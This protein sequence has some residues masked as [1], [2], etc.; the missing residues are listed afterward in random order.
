GS[1]EL[2]AAVLNEVGEGGRFGQKGNLGTLLLRVNNA[3]SAQVLQEH[4]FA[5]GQ[6]LN[7]RIGIVKQKYARILADA[8]Q[9]LL[10]RRQIEPDCVFRVGRLEHGARRRVEASGCGGA[11]R[12][13]PSSTS[14]W[15][16][17]AGIARVQ[18]QA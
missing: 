14:G 13:T 8:A 1:L 18:K 10:H 12:S 17:R 7:T 9:R 4:D 5:F 11:G 15:F 6:L 16:P 3:A 2:N